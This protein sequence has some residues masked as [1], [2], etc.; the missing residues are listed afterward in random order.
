M[1]ETITPERR[2]ALIE[3][4]ASVAEADVLTNLDAL[5]IIEILQRACERA[6]VELHEGLLTALI[7]G[8]D[9]EDPTQGPAEQE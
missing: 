8:P 4:F 7:N 1:D 9:A 3:L 2:D 5:T 6:Q